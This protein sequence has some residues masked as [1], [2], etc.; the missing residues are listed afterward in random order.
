M[1][2]VD[3][4]IP[5]LD[6]EYAIG[7]V[8]D[9]IPRSLIRRIVVVDNGSVD[10]TAR[11]AERAGAFVVREDRRGY[12]S[13]CL[14]G[15]RALQPGGDVI[16]F[17]DA[18]GSDFPDHIPRLLE[19]FE[20]GAEL[21]IGARTGPGV[22]RGALT[23][24]QRAGNALAAQWLRRRYGL[25]A[26]DLGPFR[27]VRRDAYE[28]LEMR[29]PDYGWTVEMQIKAARLKLRY[30]EVVVPYRKRVGRSKVSG[31]LRGTVGASLKILGLLARYDVFTRSPHR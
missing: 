10:A 8:L 16:L 24:Q 23:L 25:L 22:Q 2:I 19:P 28:R 30:E 21:V 4:I 29:D 11:V 15:V 12:G 6:E 27:A 26:S 1:P 9:A 31:T 7:G 13:A 18:D 5:A 14:R 20:R 3:V 17:L